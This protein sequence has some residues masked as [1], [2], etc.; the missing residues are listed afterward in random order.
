M[1]K[2]LFM[3]CVL[4]S[5]MAL[6]GIVWASDM[7]GVTDNEIKIGQWGPQ[8]GPAALWG[9]VARGTGVYFKLI[10]DEGG[11]NGRKITYFMRDD[12]YQPNR[13]KAIAKELYENEGV[14]GFACG[15]G[16]SPGM[17]VMPYIEENGIP[18]VGMATGSTHWAYPPKKPSSPYTPTIPMKLGF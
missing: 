6:S 17:A 7:Q 18:W 3:I 14:F 9:A 11:I 1:A 8:T 10:N 2:Q 16:T 12:G 5:F 13:T 15:V 4:A